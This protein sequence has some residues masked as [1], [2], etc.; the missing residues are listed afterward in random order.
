MSCVHKEC[1][2][3]GHQHGWEELPVFFYQLIHNAKVDLAE[4]ERCQKA[5]EQAGL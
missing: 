5:W 2:D 4:G 3:G 1:D